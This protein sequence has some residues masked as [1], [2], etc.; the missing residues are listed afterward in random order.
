MECIVHLEQSDDIVSIRSRIN[1][2]LANIRS[3]M[4]SGE[5]SRQR[6]QRLLLVV[7]RKNEALHSL[8][9]MK[10]LARL[11]ASK[12]TDIGVVS[13]QPTVRDYASDVGFRAFSSVRG[14][15]RFGWI[16]NAAPIVLPDQTLPPVFNPQ[17]A[18][19]TAAK[20]K[21]RTKKK[22]YKVVTENEQQS[23]LKQFIG[24]ILAGGLAV[25][26][27]IGAVLLWPSA[28]V[29][30]TP[31]A[32]PLS[33]ELIVRGDPDADRV[34]Y[35]TLT[36]PARVAQVDLSL[37]GRIDTIESEYAPT[38]LA[39]GNVTFINRTGEAQTIPLSTTLSTAS[40][41]SVDFTTV[42]T[43]EIPPGIDAV[44]RVPV[45]A[46][47]QGPSGNVS[48]GQITRFANPTYGVSVR[49]IN[50]F[51]FGGGTLALSRVV[52][53][54]D[55]DRLRTHLTEE[56]RKEGLRQLE[57]RLG[58][59][60]FISP[61]TIQVIPLAV[62]FNEFAGDFSETFS[63]EIQAV[64]RGTVVGGYNANRLSLAGLEAQVADGYE[65]ATE[66]LHFGAGEVLQAED[67][68]VIFRIVASGLAV[69]D[70]DPYHVS[71]QVAWRPIGEAQAFL[72]QQYPLATVV[73]VELQPA[74]LANWLGRLPFSPVR[75][76]VDVR[77]AVTL[78]S[79]EAN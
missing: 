45:V 17:A 43:A 44:T 64:V 46:T 18:D 41:E 29:T 22:R 47:R 77:D 56:I 73:G 16:T 32:Q 20:P 5:W 4:L 35:Q 2:V 23:Y 33:T 70:I 75:V 19:E 61:D 28:T 55:K 60:E 40:G 62:T 78:L 15:K 53:N 26:V 38:G 52:V 36:F 68:V 13:D 59:Q 27:V 66:G 79:E 48:A 21:K 69:P 67:G 74:W 51:G 11:A 6:R 63:G 10:L 31:L 65:L 7:P 58:A 49:V 30:L 37:A 12:K 24:L 54:D 76:S 50:E 34:D 71:E 1:I 25:A 8:V 72:Q 39:R 9:H 14:A 3:T 42:I 57:E